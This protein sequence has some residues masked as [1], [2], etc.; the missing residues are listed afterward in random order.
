MA[1]VGDVHRRNLLCI[2]RARIEARLKPFCQNKDKLKKFDD[3]L[4]E[5]EQEIEITYVEGQQKRSG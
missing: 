5:I 3:R 4:I 2:E 1:V